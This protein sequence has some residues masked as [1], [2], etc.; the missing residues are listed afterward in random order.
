[1]TKRRRVVLALA[2]TCVLLFLLFLRGS[3]IIALTEEELAWCR[4]YQ[5]QLPDGAEP[6]IDN[7]LSYCV[8]KEPEDHK[9]VVQTSFTSARL[10]Q[11]VPECSQTEGSLYVHK[12]TGA[13]QLSLFYST[14]QGLEVNLL[15]F[16]DS[17]VQLVIE[18]RERDRCYVVGPGISSNVKWV[19]FRSRWYSLPFSATLRLPSWLGFLFP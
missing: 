3:W 15:Y 2:G 7:I 13:R 16:D 18:E 4:Q 10:S 1:M 14:H 12:E 6:T 9:N 8:L 19:N 17:P 11:F 5:L